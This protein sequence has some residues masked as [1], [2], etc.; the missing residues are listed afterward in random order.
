[1]GESSTGILELNM[2]C[3]LTRMDFR[4]YEVKDSRVCEAESMSTITC[5]SDSE[6]TVRKPSP[7]HFI[8]RL[9]WLTRQMLIAMCLCLFI[10]TSTAMRT[11]GPD[12]D[13]VLGRSGA[14]V[15]FS[16]AMVAR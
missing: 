11:M 4:V 7:S 15:F 1:M 16:R 9:R 5:G 13:G 6:S 2:V 10:R 12:D 8:M 14:I 3:V